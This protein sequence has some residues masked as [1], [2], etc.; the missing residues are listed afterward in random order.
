M[1]GTHRLNLRWPHMTEERV[2]AVG[3]LTERDVQVLGQGFN[4]LWP[5]D[6]TPCFSQIIQAI[7]EADRQL[8]RA[9]D[10]EERMSRTSLSV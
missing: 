5:V 4:R 9:K 8:W 3:L 6:D 2:I 7:D 10:E 1:V